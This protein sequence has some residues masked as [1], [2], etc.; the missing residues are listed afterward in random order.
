MELTDWMI[1][2]LVKDPKGHDRSMTAVVSR[3]FLGG[4]EED[5]TQTQPG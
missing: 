1:N 2:E 4:T 5:H 3:N